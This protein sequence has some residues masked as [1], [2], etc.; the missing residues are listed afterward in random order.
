MK[1]I[2]RYLKMRSLLANSNNFMNYLNYL[3]V[4]FS[5][6]CFSETWLYANNCDLYALPGYSHVGKHRLHRSGGGLSIF[7]KKC[8]SDK[9]R[10]DISVVNDILESVF[11]EVNISTCNGSK[12]VIIGVIY[13]PPNTCIDKFTDIRNDIQNEIKMDNKLFYIL[14]NYNIDL[15]KC[16][17]HKPSSEFLTTI[18]ENYFYNLIDRPTRNAKTTAKLI[19]NI[20]T[21]KMKFHSY[22][23]FFWWTSMLTVPYSVHSNAFWL[24]NFMKRT[25]WIP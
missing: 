22:Q 14:G 10:L 16:N 5:V 12:T 6:L 11:V 4:E 1:N 19:N 23:E 8:Y 20:F 25:R 15:L 2:S 3:A 24:V 13:R 9:S 7:I 17:F 21:I 18:Y